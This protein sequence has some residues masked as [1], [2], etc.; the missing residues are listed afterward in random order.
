M[1]QGRRAGS[2]RRPAVLA[3]LAI[4]AACGGEALADADEY[5]PAAEG[6]RWEYSA[7]YTTPDHPEIPTRTGRRI[8]RI[9]GQEGHDGRTYLRF[10]STLEG[11]GNEPVT[12]ESLLRADSNG[13]H[14]RIDAT[15]TESLGL[16]LPPVVG[17]TWSWQD[18]WGEWRG[19]VLRELPI[20]TTA[21]RFE[22]CVEV[23]V[24][25]VTSG[26]ASR[27]QMKQLT[28]YCRGVGPVRR[29]TTTSTPGP[30]GPVRGQTE[31]TLTRTTRQEP[32]P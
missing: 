17:H 14:F 1:T 30:Q 19:S 3:L 21:G 24:E 2:E 12:G 23:S 31:E 27:G 18:S 26:S 8:D 7:H 5:Y 11:I 20:D 10:S 28:T 16:P 4:C 25:Q 13:I 6:T 22:R 29:V 32:T 15:S 9:D